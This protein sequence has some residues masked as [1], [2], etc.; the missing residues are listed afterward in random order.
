MPHRADRPPLAN[1]NRHRT[2][3]HWGC[4]GC[5]VYNGSKEC[6]MAD[7]YYDQD[8]GCS[9]PS[10][11]GATWVSGGLSYG[12]WVEHE[13]TI[14]RSRCLLE[15]VWIPLNL[16]RADLRRL[17]DLADRK[18][19][20][21]DDAG[22]D[23]MA[24]EIRYQLDDMRVWAGQPVNLRAGD[25]LE[26][27]LV[28][29]VQAPCMRTP[30]TGDEPIGVRVIDMVGTVDG[31]RAF[32]QLRVDVRPLLGVTAGD[33]ELSQREDGAP[34][35]SFIV[36]V[37]NLTSSD[38]LVRVEVVQTPA[39]WTARGEGVTVVELSA[40]QELAVRVSAW[41]ATEA[42]GAVVGPAET[43]RS[44][45]DT[46]PPACWRGHG[47][48]HPQLG[49][50]HCAQQA[51]NAACMLSSA[52]PRSLAPRPGEGF[53]SPDSGQVTDISLAVRS[54]QRRCYPCGVRTHCGR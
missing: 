51:G 36:R 46:R 16:A 27:V 1:P 15:S 39:G 30:V 42:Q 48:S 7:R 49:R 8:F 13:S 31:V 26:Q 23:E 54:G 6:V 29:E 20:A 10:T 24:S 47:R 45:S 50:Q 44:P 17:I 4:S 34:R 40:G 12:D 3:G 22:S 2:A 52:V 18:A 38:E 21:S 5:Y 11:K 25:E 19:A 53:L 33:A 41:Q 32:S 9:G 14:E 28:D 35:G 37:E 43:F